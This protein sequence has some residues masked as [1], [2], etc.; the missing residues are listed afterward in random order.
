MVMADFTGKEADD[1]R[2]ALGFHRSEE[3]MNKVITKL[4]AGMTRKGVTEEV[5]QQIVTSVQSFALYGFPESHAIGFAI[6]AYISAWLRAN[7]LAEFTCAL[8]NNQPMG[9]Y[10]SSTLV[11]DAKLHGIRIL[12]VCVVESDEGC[13]PINDSCIRLGLIQLNGIKRASCKKLVE[14]R[15]QSPWQSLKDFLLRSDLPKKERR[16]LAK[17]GALK[18]LTEH[19]RSALWEVEKEWTEDPLSTR[20]EEETASPLAMMTP[21]ERLTADYQTASLTI[22]PHPMHLIRS[23]LADVCL[24][25]DLP[26]RIHDDPI[27]IAGMV[28]CRQRPGTANGHVFVSLEDESGIANAFVHSDLFEKRRLT[29]TQEPFLKIRGRLQIVDDVI[30]IYAF[31]V[32]ALRFETDLAA[33]S[34]DFH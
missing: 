9:F 21:R 14:L 6:L 12:P 3:R 27:I 20:M 16:V 2:R 34:H 24:A 11:Q 1:L 7:R 28:I 33:S 31:A 17:A 32:E 25:A 4:R 22:G 18:K 19:R 30:T 23:K 5:Q 10:S 8:L 29:I 15:K 26:S 13:K